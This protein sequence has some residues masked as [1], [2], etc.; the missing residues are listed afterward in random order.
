VRD[1]KHPPAPAGRRERKKREARNRILQAAFELFRKH[2][3]AGTTVEEIAERADVGKG[4]VFNY[5]PQKAAFLDAWLEQWSESFVAELGPASRWRGTT[6]NKM[7][8]MMRFFADLAAQ[9]PD[10]VREAFVE[11]MRRWAD[12][13]GIEATHG[14][15][16]IR[17]AIRTILNDGKDAGDVRP[18]L[19]TEHAA[20]LIE[21]A[22]HRTFVYWLRTR[23][24][25]RHLH[26]EIAAK[27]EIIFNGLAPIPRPKR[28]TTHSTGRTRPRGRR[29]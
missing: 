29:S 27:L 22:M 17:D 19:E 14:A 12:S 13:I 6:R 8:R 11:D 26:R 3:F 21:T 16:E 4:T 1:A 15:R 10:L 7:E 24:A 23:P 25:T 9:D 5:F 28:S 20:T 18:D 2:G